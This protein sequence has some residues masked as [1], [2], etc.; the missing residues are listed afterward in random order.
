M[1]L[2]SQAD[3][4]NASI[5]IRLRPLARPSCE[6]PRPATKGKPELAGVG[7]D[8]SLVLS[9]GLHEFDDGGA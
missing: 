2:Q 8:L 7:Q 3:F 4:E 5:A 1:G 6:G 9:N